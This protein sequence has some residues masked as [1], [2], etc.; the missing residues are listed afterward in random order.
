MITDSHYA[1][2]LRLVVLLEAASL[3]Y[4]PLIN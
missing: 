4:T 3:V 2:P 1:N